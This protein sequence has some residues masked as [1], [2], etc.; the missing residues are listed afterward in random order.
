MES[1]L[2]TDWF[3]TWLL[4]VSAC[5]LMQRQLIGD[6]WEDSR[7]LDSDAHYLAG[8]GYN[9]KERLDKSFRKLS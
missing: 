2:F 4:G 9:D 5:M 8:E 6:W 1:V 3:V 7:M